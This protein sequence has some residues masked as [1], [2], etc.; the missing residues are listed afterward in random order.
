M[1]DL[2]L[3]GQRGQPTH[4]AS[5]ARQRSSLAGEAIY[6]EPEDQPDSGGQYGRSGSAGPA[7]R[8]QPGWDRSASADGVDPATASRQLATA[9]ESKLKLAPRKQCTKQL[10][11]EDIALSPAA[12]P[13]SAG[14]A[15]GACLAVVREL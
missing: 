12:D 7:P 1:D 5:R 4:L 8:G 2:A 15:V 10:C 6:E 13:R 11:P 14:S 9:V 3:L